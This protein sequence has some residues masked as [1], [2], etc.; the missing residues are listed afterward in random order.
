M[1]NSYQLA[2]AAAIAAAQ[3]YMGYKGLKRKGD[4]DPR[5]KDK[6]RRK[7]KMKSRKKG[8]NKS[9]KGAHKI[10]EGKVIYNAPLY[11]TSNVVTYK[12][13]KEVRFAKKLGNLCTYVDTVTWNATTTQGIQGVN[14]IYG[15]ANGMC[16]SQKLRDIYS[17]AFISWN[18]T[19]GAWVTQI[20]NTAT[21]LHNKFLLKG[22]KQVLRMTNQSPSTVELDL[23]LCQAKITRATNI[24]ADTDW[25]LG[26]D[27]ESV[28]F[29][30]ANN[31][32]TAY[33]AKPTDAKRFNMNWRIIKTL[34]LKLNPGEE[35]RHSYKFKANR[36]LDTG[37]IN[38]YDTINGLHH[39]WLCVI[40]GVAAD[41]TQGFAAGNITTT[42]AKVVGTCETTYSSYLI[43][44]TPRTSYQSTNVTTANVNV[45][46]IADAA[47]T[48]TNNETATNFA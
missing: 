48:V 47:G 14:T 33:G 11:D 2:G 1:V 20:A 7:T 36:I 39:T 4:F 17:K 28:N 6:K 15:G 19:A 32:V 18:S 21:Q 23:Y 25:T 16:G 9:K 38:Q 22:T 37:Y 5:K 13:P 24:D 8:K 46:T 41:T 12:I 30:A 27:A 43:N 26:L 3:A 34:K 40:R 44:W 31:D 29:P 45:Y 10:K 42:R 35:H